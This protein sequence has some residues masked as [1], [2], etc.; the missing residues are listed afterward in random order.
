MALHRSGATTKSAAA[1][2]ESA[3]PGSPARKVVGSQ[4]ITRYYEKA[5]CPASWIIKKKLRPMGPGSQPRGTRPCIEAQPPSWTQQ[6]L[7]PVQLQ[8]HLHH[9]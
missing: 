2:A 9:K 7:L 6:L 3:A 8:A 5:Y 4:G 1:A